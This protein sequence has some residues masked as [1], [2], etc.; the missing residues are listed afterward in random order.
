MPV[1]RPGQTSQSTLDFI[2][3]ASNDSHVE[4]IF[5]DEFMF[6]DTKRDYLPEPKVIYPEDK[7]DEYV[8]NQVIVGFWRFPPSLD[9][10]ASKYGGKLMDSEGV[11]LSAKFTVSNISG[12][13][14]KVSTDPYVRYAEPN[15]IGHALDGDVIASENNTSGIANTPKAPGFEAIPAL[16]L[17]SSAVYI[18]KRRNDHG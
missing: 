5:R 7:K 6:T 10:F 13:I 16:G 18:L 4:R 15:G 9:E 2:K 1:G 8:P 14:K 17:L 11:L 3:K 12:F